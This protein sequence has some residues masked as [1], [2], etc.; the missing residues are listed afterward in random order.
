MLRVRGVSYLVDS[1]QVDDAR[2]DLTAIVEGLHCNA[3][4]LVG[5]DI[6]RLVSCAQ[7]AVGLGLEVYLRPDATDLRPDAMLH[8][9]ADVARRAGTI[10]G[11]HPDSITLLV[12]SEFSHT[13]AGVVPGPRSFIRL[14]VVLRLRRLLRRRVRRRLEALLAR[15]AAVAR[16]NFDGPLG[17]AAAAWE[18]V[19]WTL[20][21]FVGVSLYRSAGNRAGYREQVR[22]LAT[23]HE[24][25]LLITEFGCGAFAGADDRG[26]GS[27]QVVDWFSDPPRIRGDVARD[28][29]VQATYLTELIDLYD[30]EDVHGCFV[31]TYAMPDYPR[32]TDPAH[33]LDKAGFGLV[34]TDG[35]GGE[36]QR[37]QAFDAVAGRF[38]AIASREG[39]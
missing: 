19:D 2:R 31:F 29:S 28:E 17:Y 16:E 8:R 36:P 3:V 27:F 24:P 32:R 23:D 9:L 4:M 12:G 35:N 37:K 6:D 20:F 18:D 15:A 26:A 39:R 25:P 33:D 10:R 30:A 1:A 21:D 13:V 34:C 7:I 11:Q 5:A 38:A 14:Q 22:R